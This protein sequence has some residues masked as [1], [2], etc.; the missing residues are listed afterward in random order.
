M[1]RNRFVWH[2]FGGLSAIVAA[3]AAAAFW[4]ASIQL[5]GLADAALRDRLTDVGRGLAA[6]TL[7]AGGGIDHSSF[8]A[9][10]RSLRESSR[11][12][13][14]L[15]DGIDATGTD[16][17]DDTIAAARRD[18]IA[19]R[20]RYDSGSGRRSLEVAVPVPT[21]PRSVILVTGDAASSDRTLAEW[22]RTLLLG[23]LAVTAVAAAIAYA[24][25]RQLARPLDGLRAAAARL[26]SGD[27]RADPPAT[28][29]AEFA[30]LATALV[31]LREQLV[32]RGLTIGRQD[33]QQEAVLGSMIEGVLAI[34]GRRRILGINRAAADLLDVEADAAAGRPMQDVIR[35]PDL[36][37]F[38]LT[39]IDC[40]EPVEDDLLLRGVRD[41]TIRLRGTALRDASGD[42]GAVI[43]LNDVT[44]VQRLEH[45]RRDFVANVSHELK[46]PVASIKGFVETLLDGALDDHADARRFLGIVSRQADRLASIIED[47]LALSRI[48]QSETS[49]TLPLERQPLAGLLVAATDDCRPRA[50]ER[51]I[52]VELACPPM[53]MVTVNGPLLEQAVINLVDNAIKYSEPGKTVWLS[54]DADADGT[55]IRVRDEGCGI[56]AEHLPRLFERF[57]R[58]DK[59]RSRNLGG[60]GLGLSI[61]KHIVQAH[62]GTIAVESTPGVGTTFTIRLPAG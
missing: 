27:V 12:D 23:C 2:V 38:A 5:A 46:T 25:A 62:A 11:I 54:A 41:R 33:T 20:S 32:E 31:R 26:A 15:I 22:Q 18:G 42:G 39:A 53:L 43:V 24:L 4:I 29:V 10:A 40:R 35:N 55:A 1:P 7:A 14:R 9:G 61:V 21:S 36:R 13:C 51:S 16:D 30:D 60:T 37:R 28:D 49:G 17:T 48:E 59:A 34:D 47:L 19:S 50:T 57:Y 8:E 6:A 52:R 44:E 45:V 58:V 56:A 3:T